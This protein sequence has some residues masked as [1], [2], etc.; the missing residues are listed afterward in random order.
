MSGLAVRQRRRRGIVVEIAKKVN[1]QAPYGAASS[2]MGNACS[3]IYLHAVF[4]VERRQNLIGSSVM[5]RTRDTFSRT[6]WTGFPTMSL[7]TE[8][9]R[10][11]GFRSTTISPLAGLEFLPRLDWF[12]DVASMAPGLGISRF[13]DLAW[14]FQ[15]RPGLP[16]AP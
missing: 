12:N 3:E 4:A 6:L 11:V 1:S 2:F 9:E 16:P 5:N 15:I 10:P 7:L 14:E 8:L 13:P